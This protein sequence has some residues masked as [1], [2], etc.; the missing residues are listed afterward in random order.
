[1]TD[2]GKNIVLKREGSDQGKRFIEA[3]NPGSVKL[4]D[5]SL[6]EWMQFAYRF[7]SHVNYFGNSSFEEPEGNWE[8]FFKKESEIKDFLEEVETESNITP[9]LA[10]FVCFVRLLEFSKNRFNKLTKRHLDFYY[11]EILKI[12]KLPAT[13]DKV[14]ILYE[15][16][17][18]VTEERIST[19]TLLDGGKDA[20]G[21]KR[22]YKTMDE[23]VVNRAAVAQIKSVYTDVENNKIKVAESA[24]SFDGKGTDFP[25]DD[26]RWWPF[27]Y[28]EPENSSGKEREYPELD[29]A[30]L[31]FAISSDILKLQEGDRYIQ[32]QIEFSS[33]VGTQVIT[34]LTENLEVWCT[35]EK[36]WLG[37]YEFKPDLTDENKNIVFSTKYENPLKF[38]FHIP[39]DEKSVSVYNAEIH[40]GNYNTEYPVCRV[41]IKTDKTDGILLYRQ[42]FEKEISNLKINIDVRGVESLDLENDIGL[43][44][45][46]KPFYPFGTQSV[47][48][49]NF[50]INYPELFE[51]EW[52]AINVKIVW[53]N[54]PDSFKDLYYAYRTDYLYKASPSVFLGGMF[55]VVQFELQRSQLMQFNQNPENLIVTGDNHFKA[56][57]QIRHNAKWENTVNNHVLFTADGNG[58]YFSE[59]EIRKSNNET[60]PFRMSLKQSFYHEFFPRIYALAFTSKE[61]DAL[62]PNEPYTPLIETVSLDYTASAKMSFGSSEKDFVQNKVKLFH[63]HSFGQNEEHYYLKGNLSFMEDSEKKVFLLPDYNK[64]GELYIG[65]EDAEPLQIV[66]LLIQ[67]LEGTE[68]PETD[69][70]EI[71]AKAEWSVLCSNQWKPLDSDFM[72]T[73]ETENFL[74]SGIVK[75]SLPRD[76][77]KDNTRLEPGYIWVRA[78]IYGNYDMVSKAVAIY[79]QAVKA[80]FSD[81]GNELSHLKNGLEVKTIS[82]Q[83]QRIPAVKGLTQPYTSFGGN[84]EESDAEYYRRISERLRHKNR[85][86]TVWDYEHLILQQFPEIYKVKCLNHTCHT[87]FL[88]PGNVYVVVI[89]DIFN[90]NVFDIFQPRVSKAKLVEIHDFVNRLNSMQVKVRVENPDYEEVTADLKVK[91]YKGYD[92]S[93]Y[94]K[95]LNEDIIRL[96]S[97]WAFRETAK[98]EF[99]SSLHISTLVHYIEKLEYVDYVEDVKMR[100]EGEIT[101]LANAGSPKA[102]LVSARQHNILPAGV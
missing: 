34:N 3:L 30:K 24:N 90:N 2:T 77:G 10:L 55:N 60:G 50:Q 25:D 28:Y 97:P 63:E 54:T 5:F 22:F 33:S 45:G 84:P 42:L 82:K 58:G 75:F 100:V 74:K 88:A 36:G 29:D 4:N 99:G 98:I 51:K 76:A 39:S 48:H 83:I 78:R 71:N 62:I 67:M 18:K 73:D 1:M 93:F 38:A 37:P 102:I 56:D 6:K 15:L 7:A 69:L 87:S 79:A 12:E 92:E 91:F 35:G 72:I 47:K 23:L 95:K 14:Y 43:L 53:K 9:H 17:K 32:L 80:R 13:S 94:L 16:A 20:N 8:L 65:L 31:G 44:N 57:I 70:P 21:Q 19:D 27:G 85:A 11:G 52:D 89:P 40:G 26:I 46:K 66:S 96:L 68:N 41:I 86:V 101:S 59:F 61:K 49:S 81:N 64:G